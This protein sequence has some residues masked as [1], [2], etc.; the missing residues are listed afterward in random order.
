M[1]DT[2]QTPPA[3]E[4][5][6]RDPALGALPDTVRASWRINLD[7]LQSNL[8]HN[9]PDVVELFT[10][11][12]LYCIDDAHPLRLEEFA[13]Q[14]GT[15]RTTISRLVQG[16]Y[17][18]PATGARQPVSDRLIKALR[19]FRSLAAERAKEIKTGFVTTPTARRIFVACDLARESRSP[20]FLIGPSHIGK[21]WALQEYTHLNNHGSTIYVRMHAASGLM[22]MVRGIAAALGYSDRAATP[23]LTLR[24]KSS[25]KK[26]PNTLLIFD[27]LHQLF[28]TYRK[29]S[30]F[31]CLEVLREIYDET[32]VGIVLCGTELLFTRVKNNRGE[33][34]QLLRRGVHKVVLPDQPQRADIAAIIEPLGLEMPEKKET[35]TVRVG[36]VP[37]TDQPYDILKQLGR[38]EGLK[39]ITERLRY[40][41][42]LAR[43]ADEPLGWNHFVRAHHTIRQNSVA[44]NDWE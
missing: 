36:G 42:R 26:R 1:A 9:S 12:F 22:G 27:E 39:A 20:V 43:K 21:T 2:T 35:L 32:G 19:Q 38:E 40:A 41:T 23:E 6:D 29:E 14:V 28:H 33:L 11:C 37:I 3:D 25:L 44:T 8:S 17:K 18:H 4:A 24:I 5:Q 15:D 13:L 16:T 30:F 34:E 31:A 10:W 7:T